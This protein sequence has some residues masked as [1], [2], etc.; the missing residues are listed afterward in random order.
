L[1]PFNSEL[2]EQS[3]GEIVSIIYDYLFEQR[4][5]IKYLSHGL[6]KN[7]IGSEYSDEEIML[8]AR[9]LAAL[10][11]PLLEEKYEFV[12]SNYRITISRKV[13]NRSIKEGVFIHPNT[14]EEIK[15]FDELI[16]IFYVPHESFLKQLKS[17][18]S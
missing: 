9:A 14:G 6:L 12:T 1:K 7:R 11:K 16:H 8:A 10:K 3:T 2:Y 13:L 17:E 5:K 4:G 18:D 15:N